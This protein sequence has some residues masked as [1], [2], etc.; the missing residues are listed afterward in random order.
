MGAIIA[1]VNKK[2]DNATN[3]AVSMLEM[4]NY[5][6]AEAFGIASQNNVEIEKSVEALCGRIIKSPITIGYAFSK[7]LAS[8]KPQPMMMK[9]ATFVFDG[10]LYP[11]IAET[12]DAEIVAEK[13]QKNR[14]ENIKKLIQKVEGEF[15]FVIAESERLIAGRDIM[16]LR[17]L[18]YGEN[19]EYA[20]LASERKAL[21]K[22][23]IKNTYSFPPG[24]VAFINEN[25][26]EFEPI[27]TLEYSKTKQTSMQ[28]A[29]KNL[30]TLLQKSVEER[31]SGLKEVALAFSGGLD[32]SL[33]ARL[34]KN[35]GVKVKLIHVSLKN[36]PETKHAEKAAEALKLPI[37]SY[38]YEEKDVAE[39]LPKVLWLIEEPDPVKVS[40][41]VPFYWVAENA[42][43]M[44][45]K[46]L[47]AGQGADEL[48][49]GYKRYVNDYWRYG[50]GRVQEKIFNDIAKMYENNF[51]RDFK[52]C[53]FHNVELRL[54]FATYSMANFAINLPLEL[55]IN[56]LDRGVRKIVLRRL[57][58]KLGL[59]SCITE[60]EKKAIQYATGVSKIL[61]K[62]A[63]NKGLSQKEYLQ[64]TFQTVLK[65][66]M[67]HE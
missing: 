9:D 20:A 31:V 24:H 19:I 6:K 5:K 55:K 22:I 1:V 47:L 59:P 38:L 27:K 54:P 2:G 23:G 45:L 57:G 15:T 39:T 25:G 11:S 14:K 18:Y 44:R 49:G 53:N 7:I 46:I 8:D 32:S 3:I 37:Y 4:L 62:L 17:P 10:R 61:H 36:Q 51:E 29:T 34:A 50:S 26:F 67:E 28:A 58:K 12:Y 30:Q 35:S 48:F 16:G 63:N 65:R 13:L 42:A 41:G 43:K 33:I 64:Q 66:M 40:I 56:L 21:W 52:I 60:R